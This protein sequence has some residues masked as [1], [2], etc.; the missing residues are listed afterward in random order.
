MPVAYRDTAIGVIGIYENN[1]SIE[2]LYFQNATVPVEYEHGENDII[3]AAFLQLEEY[4][5]GK[6]KSFELPLLPQGT[7]F[8]R[9]CW[10]ALLEI[11]YGETA[12]Y[13]EIAEKIGCP[14]GFRAVGLAN[15]RNP[16]AVFIPC[17]RVVGANGALTGFA[18]GLDVKKKLL[19][20]ERK[21]KV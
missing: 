12:T 17:H 4:L 19:D 10:N 2:K 5:A 1:G 13:G 6:R 15:N 21:N 11:P 7:E 18:G 20:L 16:V 3:N 8:Q 9:K 14:K